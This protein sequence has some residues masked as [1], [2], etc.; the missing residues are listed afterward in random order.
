[1]VLQEDR[2]VG[3]TVSEWSSLSTGIPASVVG[4]GWVVLIGLASSQ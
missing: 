4:L 1:M 3:P 2:S